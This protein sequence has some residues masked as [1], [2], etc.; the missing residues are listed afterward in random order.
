[1]H[2]NFKDGGIA[3]VPPGPTAEQAS[4]SNRPHVGPAAVRAVSRQYRRERRW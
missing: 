1:M 4:T 2:E 3:G